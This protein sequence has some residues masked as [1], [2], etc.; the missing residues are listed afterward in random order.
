MRGN[1]VYP[2][3]TN[4]ATGVLA[5]IGRL[6]AL[7]IDADAAGFPRITVTWQRHDRPV[8]TQ[9]IWDGAGFAPTTD[10]AHGS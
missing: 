3:M 5:P 6:D 1:R 9:F 4:R 10:D 7:H 8:E 2:L